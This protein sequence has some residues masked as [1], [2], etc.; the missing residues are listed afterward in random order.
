MRIIF[1]LMVLAIGTCQCD[2]F[3]KDAAQ[4]NAHEV[5]KT[6][7]GSVSNSFAE[8][9]YSILPYEMREFLSN[10]YE[11]LMRNSR[12]NTRYDYWIHRVASEDKLIS[13]A[14][15]VKLGAS[16]HLAK[17]LGSMVEVIFEIA[18]SA[19]NDDPLCTELEKNIRMIR[20]RNNGLDFRIA[21]PGYAN[22]S[23]E[24]AAR[25]LYKLQKDKDKGNIYPKMVVRTA[26]LWSA[27]W[28]AN[29]KNALSEPRVIARRPA[30]LNIDSNLNDPFQT[31][32][33]QTPGFSVPQQSQ[34]NADYQ[35][36]LER[37]RRINEQQMR[38]NDS[39]RYY[40]Y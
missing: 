10:D 4:E 3:A 1:L 26:D 34:S 40:G 16:D 7:S 5:H 2:A 15:T 23:I 37:L 32:R 20:D 8:D 9:V 31:R 17:S 14:K 13:I 6:F 29:G 30:I 39:R 27:I 22:Q 18:M 33:M 12:V 35:E 11:V 28:A 19:G 36:R 38:D 25:Q 21:Y 24:T